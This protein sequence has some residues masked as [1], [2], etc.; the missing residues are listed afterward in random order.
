[1]ALSMHNLRNLSN[2]SDG[3]VLLVI[4]IHCHPP[5]SIE[6]ALPGVFSLLLN[7]GQPTPSSTEGP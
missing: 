5:L 4:P 6:C 7:Y 3:M 1:M 2:G